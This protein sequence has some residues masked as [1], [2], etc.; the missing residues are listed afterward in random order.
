MCRLSIF[1][2]ALDFK[3]TKDSYSTGIREIKA[4]PKDGSCLVCWRMTVWAMTVS[5][6]HWEGVWAT[7]FQEHC[8][9]KGC[10]SE[11]G[12]REEITEGSGCKLEV[13]GHQ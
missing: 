7:N 10:P 4:A 9:S 13:L 5:H 11:L 1:E 8:K 12:W 3:S 2:Q 6:P